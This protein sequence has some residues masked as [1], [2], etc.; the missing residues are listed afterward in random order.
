MYTARE[1]FFVPQSDDTLVPATVLGPGAQSETVQIEYKRNKCLVKHPIVFNCGKAKGT[2]PGAACRMPEF[3]SRDTGLLT[4]M[5][6]NRPL[7]PRSNIA[8]S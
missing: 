4:T 8:G 3:F 2:S 6:K 5:C 1:A 7:G